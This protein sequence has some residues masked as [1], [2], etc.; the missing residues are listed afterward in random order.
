MPILSLKELKDALGPGKRLMGID[1]GMKTWGLAL[2]DPSLKIATPLTVIRRTKFRD[3]IQKLA[4]LCR[5]YEVGGFVIGLPLNMDG[6][7]GP[8]AESVTHFAQNLDSA[9]EVLGFSP[10]IALFDERLST[11]AT[12][13]ALIED[14]DM[15]RKKR[16]QHIDAHAAAHILR[17]ALET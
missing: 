1:H 10:P 5:E 12:E 4:A 9:A 6:S 7:H 8:R 17:G 2:A 3:D 15:S 13:Q 14:L 16:A 11:W